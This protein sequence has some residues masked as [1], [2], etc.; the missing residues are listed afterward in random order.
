MKLYHVSMGWTET[1]KLFIPRIP[2]TRANFE[3]GITKRICLSTSIEGCL[4]AMAEK[5][6]RYNTK[7]T[8][9]QCDVEDFVRYDELYLSGK[10]Y[11]ACLT[12][13]CWYLKPLVMDGKYVF[14]KEFACDCQFVPLE[15]KK[16][17]LI[18]RILSLLEEY[19]IDIP[20]DI[21]LLEHNTMYDLMYQILPS[22]FTSCDLDLEDV[23][24]SIGL[25]SLRTMYHLKFSDKV[26]L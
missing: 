7:L 4:N 1:P 9:Y 20:Y 23:F 15:H 5:P 24:G 8:I 12:Q 6:Y 2:K 21:T 14:L 22:Y 13:E 10:V 25:P 26:S 11:D 18:T 17:E 19:P 16:K 3:D